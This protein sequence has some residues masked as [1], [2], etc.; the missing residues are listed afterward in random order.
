M[1]PTPEQRAYAEQW[2]VARGKEP[3]YSLEVW[4]FWN[5][6]D[7]DIVG[8]SHCVPRTLYNLFHSNIHPTR[9]AAIDA[10]ALALAECRA[11]CEIPTRDIQPEDEPQN[12][13]GITQ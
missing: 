6:D 7:A 8:E 11:A 2:M 3:I 5:E 13:K 9:D 4:S 10:L 12:S 1:T